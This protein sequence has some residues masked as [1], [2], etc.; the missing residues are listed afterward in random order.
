MI[1]KDNEFLG[2]IHDVLRRLPVVS[3]ELLED[4]T[5]LRDDHVH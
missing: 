1:V 4:M 3:F 2:R 5:H